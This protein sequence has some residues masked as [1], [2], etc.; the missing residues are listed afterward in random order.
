[1]FGRAPSVISGS[2]DERAYLPP[3]VHRFASGITLLAAGSSAG[4]NEGSVLRVISS[5]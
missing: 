4:P 2:P 1:M 3:A 5:R